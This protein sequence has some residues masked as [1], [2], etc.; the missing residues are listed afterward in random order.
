[1]QK[2]LPLEWMQSPLNI[3]HNNFIQI[4]WQWRHNECILLLKVN[5]LEETGIMYFWMD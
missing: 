2:A 5:V 3:Y 4:P 1:M